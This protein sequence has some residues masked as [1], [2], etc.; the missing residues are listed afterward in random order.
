[1]KTISTMMMKGGSGKTTLTRILASAALAKNLKVHIFDV[2]TDPQGIGWEA[3]FNRASWGKITKPEW[4]HDR[5]TISGAVAQIDDLYDDMDRMEREGYDLVLVDTRPGAYRD[6][7]DLIVATEL[8]LIP[9]RPLQ[10]DYTVAERTVEWFTK[11]VGTIEEGSPIPALRTIM[12]DVPRKL[13]SVLTGELGIDA[14]TPRDRDAL[15]AIM[16]MPHAEVVVPESK[17]WQDLSAWGPLGVAADAASTQSVGR[18]Q[19]VAMRDLLEGASA[20]L[21]EMFQVIDSRNKEGADK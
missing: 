16:Q 7:E 4:P 10:S 20:L 13:I 2:D 1:M 15:Q 8:V 5:L 19:A 14:L 18:L 12:T 17:Y 11:I 6:T 3:S 21:D 9:T